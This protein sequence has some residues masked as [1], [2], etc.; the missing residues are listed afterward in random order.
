ME[1]EST[2][3]RRV[4]VIRPDDRLD[5]GVFSAARHLLREILLHRDHIKVAFRQDFRNLYQG[6]FFGVIWNIVLPLVPVLI[7]ALLSLYRVLPG[8]EGVNPGTYVALGATVWFLLAGCVQ[9][10]LQT[11]RARNAEVMKTALPLSAMVVSSFAQLLFDTLMRV[12]LIAV[13]ILITATEVHSTALLIPLALLPAI[14]LFFGLGLILGVANV[15]YADVG[16]VTGI[17]IQ[18][19]IFISGV[20]FPIALLPFNEILMWNPAYVLIEEVRILCFRGL[21]ETGWLLG[22]Y[23]VVGI[24]VFFW[25]CRIFYLMEYRVRGVG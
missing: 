20:I 15:I 18:Y 9:Q 14:M 23:A 10:P 3:T 12:A 19:G 7:Y 6:T 21:P 4:R 5:A 22:A 17:A 16:R 11:V 2:L 25:G 1:K 13:M 8:F 24:L